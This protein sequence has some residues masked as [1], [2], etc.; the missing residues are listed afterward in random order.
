M[1]WIC[2]REAMLGRRRVIVVAAGSNDGSVRLAMLC[3]S[4]QP[5]GLVILKMSQHRTTRILFV[6]LL[7]RVH[8]C[9]SRTRL[10]SKI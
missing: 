9:A 1:R 4:R 5:S 3:S 6:W 2:V 10:R 8:S 7:N